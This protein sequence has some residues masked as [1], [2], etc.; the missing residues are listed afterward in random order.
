MDN[1]IEYVENINKK[2]VVKCYC[3]KC[4][5]KI[6][7]IILSDVCEN[8]S[9]IVECNDGLSGYSIEWKDDYQIIKCNGCDTITFRKY[10]WFSEYQDMENDGHYTENYP[11]SDQFK[12]ALTEF[13][14]LPELIE[15]LYTESISSYNNNCDLLCAIGLRTIIESVC[16]DKNIKSGKIKG[17]NGKIK[18][19]K[20]LEGMING[21]CE[22]EIITE[23]QTV[24]LHQLRLIGN[25]AVHDF[26]SPSKHILDASFRIID[27]LL[28]VIYE[29]PRDEIEIKKRK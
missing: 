19:S 11:E 25:N 16:K 26:R 17:A 23:K 24:I 10:G 27:L 6:N 29:L 22:A 9:E 3:N 13:K 5:I 4:K 14:Y 28:K 8:G 2:K 12:K 18:V 7:H 1:E 15:D 21:L 20:T